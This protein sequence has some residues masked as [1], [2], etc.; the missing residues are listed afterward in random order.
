MTEE[1]SNKTLMLSVIRAFREGDTAPLFAALSLQI[2]WKSNAPREFFRSGGES[3]GLVEM[4]AR[5]AGIFAQYHFVRFDPTAIVTQGDTVIGQ[6]EVEAFH[7]RS[8][9]TVKTDM[10]I[11]WTVRHGK[12]M[13]HQSFFDTA[14]VL[15]QQGDVKAA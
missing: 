13:Q 6:F 7:Q 9:K 15:L 14:A 1:L 10:S 2:V 11:R 8:G 3:S 4:K 5:I 12:I